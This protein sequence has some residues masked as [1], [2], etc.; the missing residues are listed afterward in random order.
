MDS[1]LR[2][3]VDK[4]QTAMCE[5]GHTH[6]R[7]DILYTFARD[8][9]NRLRAQAM[10]FIG[11]CFAR[12]PLLDKLFRID[13]RRG[14]LRSTKHIAM[15][16]VTILVARPSARI[17]LAREQKLLEPFRT[18]KRIQRFERFEQRCGA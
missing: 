14:A 16:N 10:Q 9:R 5:L 17:R 6:A 18:P 15:G 12:K 3:R 4:M 13:G 8:I 2:E 11:N 7:V 1:N